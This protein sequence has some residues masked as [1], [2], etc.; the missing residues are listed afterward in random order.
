MQKRQER[1]VT[2]KEGRGGRVPC[3]GLQSQTRH[4]YVSRLWGQRMSNSFIDVQA[5]GDT[6][7]DAQCCREMFLLVV[8]GPTGKSRLCM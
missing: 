3:G 5:C 8:S 4:V 7:T 2:V 6:H 1:K